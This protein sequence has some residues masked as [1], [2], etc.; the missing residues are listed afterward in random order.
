MGERGEILEEG[1]E[2][3][4]KNVHV[5]TKVRLRIYIYVAYRKEYHL[6]W[7]S[8]DVE[9]KKRDTPRTYWSGIGSRRHPGSQ[10]S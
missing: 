9:R 2:D 5:G 10:V 4:A 7:E 3:R 8:K 1:G 6:G